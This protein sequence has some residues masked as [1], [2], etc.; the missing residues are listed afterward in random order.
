MIFSLKQESST[1]DQMS[2]SMIAINSHWSNIQIS[3]VTVHPINITVRID[4]LNSLIGNVTYFVDPIC[5]FS[6]M[7][8][9]QNSAVWDWKYRMG[10]I[11]NDAIVDVVWWR[12]PYLTYL[13]HWCEINIR[14]NSPKHDWKANVVLDFDVSESILS[15]KLISLNKSPSGFIHFIKSAWASTLVQILII[16]W[17]GQC[18]SQ[19]ISLSRPESRP[20]MWDFSKFSIPSRDVNSVWVHNHGVNS[21]PW[22]SRWTINFSFNADDCTWVGYCRAL[23]WISTWN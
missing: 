12:S 23:S 2:K 4:N 11:E 22:I 15:C 7:I 18:K 8:D 21:S 16:R 6:H 19:V 14:N 3:R 5:C 9:S 20:C 17:N 13:C 1:I 10:W